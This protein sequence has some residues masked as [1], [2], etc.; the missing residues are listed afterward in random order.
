MREFQI[1]NPLGERLEGERK[2]RRNW[3]LGGVG[4]LTF[5]VIMALVMSPLFWIGGGV[6]FF[7][8]IFMDLSSR[9][10]AEVYRKGLEGEEALK[11]KLKEILS[12]K[13]VALYN[14]PLEKGG[15][16]ID[17][18]LVGPGGVILLDAKNYGGD[19]LCDHRGR[20]TQTVVGRGGRVHRWD[21]QSPSDQMRRA[22]FE[23]KDLFRKHGMDLWIEGIIVFTNP[24]TRVVT[25]KMR[26]LRVLRLGDIGKFFEERRDFLSE[27]ASDKLLTCLLGSIKA[28]ER[29]S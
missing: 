10:A 2:A 11:G 12:D 8:L 21:I 23:I 16:D 28:G 14:F 29:V 22:V 3:N 18:L 20:W 26:H 7:T 15:G 24:E 17:C 6:I 9:K 19:I 4:I 13:Y 27:K 1:L 5:T 25:R